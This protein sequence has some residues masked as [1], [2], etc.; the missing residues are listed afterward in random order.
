MWSHRKYFEYT[1]KHRK[2]IENENDSQF[3]DYRDINQ[4]ERS[5]YIKKNLVN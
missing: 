3:D 4:E 2:I 5:I 1:D